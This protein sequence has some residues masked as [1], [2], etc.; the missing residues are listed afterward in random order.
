MPA[1]VRRFHGA[2]ALVVSGGLALSGV[3][4]AAGP[5]AAA[6]LA[7]GVVFSTIDFDG[8]GGAPTC[9]APT[10]DKNTTAPFSSDTSAKT[11]S[12]TSS[13]TITDSADPADVTTLTGRSTSTASLTGAGGS[14]RSVD[15]STSLRAT[16]AAAQ[17]ASTS[18]EGEA[19]AL[20]GAETGFSISEPGWLSVTVSKSQGGLAV[21]AVGSVDGMFQTYTIRVRAEDSYRFYLPAAGDYALVLQAQVA[22][23]VPDSPFE[24][25]E[26]ETRARVH[27]EFRAAGAASGKSAGPGARYLRLADKRSCVADTLK[28]T[29]TSRA[30][31]LKS[32][33][34]FVNGTRR[35]KVANPKGGRA[36][37]LGG[38]PDG[39]PVTVKAVLARKQG[40]PVTVTRSYLACS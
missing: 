5:A 16:W 21:L 4:V 39:K 35:A 30:G 19:A 22:V 37:T 26:E 32:A 15:I 12:N 25:R 33:Q 1:P 40:G 36:V 27:G 14:L 3:V 31:Q 8:T 34:I 29:F 23:E 6:P 2:L 11:V 10:G 28:A 20:G 13:T 18:C 38:L 9:S 7:E 17:G 24:P